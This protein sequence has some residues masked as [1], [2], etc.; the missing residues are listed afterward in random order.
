MN[1][2]AQN[3]LSATI[4]VV[5]LHG[6]LVASHIRGASSHAK[7]A[8]AGFAIAGIALLAALPVL[9]LAAAAGLHQFAGLG[10]A[11]S[12]L[13]AG[14]AGLLIAGLSGALAYWR[15]RECRDRLS[16]IASDNRETFRWIKELTT[17]RPARVSE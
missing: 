2:Q 14:G 8:A 7:T 6:R 13:S 16:H 1:E 4:D 17:V 12:L 10:V 15:L 9:L 3:M 11:A 5:E